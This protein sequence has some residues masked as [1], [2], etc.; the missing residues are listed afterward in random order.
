MLRKH[1]QWA[2]SSVLIERQIFQEDSLRQ[3][4]LDNYHN[5]R[6]RSCNGRI[7]SANTME[8]VK[9]EGGACTTVTQLPNAAVN[10][11]LRTSLAWFNFEHAWTLQKE[12]VRRRIRRALKAYDSD[13]LN[14]SGWNMW[15]TGGTLE[16]SR[17]WHS[18]EYAPEAAGA[19]LDG[20]TNHGARQT[21]ANTTP[22][23]IPS[24]MMCS[25][26]E[27]S[28]RQPGV[29]NYVKGTT[30]DIR[31]KRC[32]QMRDVCH[33]KRNSGRR[34]SKRGTNLEAR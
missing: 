7:I 15:R 33:E 1:S 24:T 22:D 16:W 32:I 25:N 10:T 5:N 12:M 20:S 30:A 18:P 28:M 11:L 9:K 17:W 29:H 8:C 6:G 4:A 27:C 2:N 14:L 19:Q 31:C 21:A 3:V 23:E 26:N 13:V 34:I